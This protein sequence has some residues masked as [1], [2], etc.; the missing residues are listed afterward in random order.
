MTLK[1]EEKGK[2]GTTLYNQDKN[3]K[4]ISKKVSV[5]LKQFISL[6]ERKDEK[7]KIAEKLNDS[8]VDFLQKLKLLKSS[9]NC[10][11]DTDQLQNI[12]NL[13]ENMERL[14]YQLK[15]EKG[16]IT[17][18][19]MKIQKADA[20]RIVVWKRKSR[21]VIKDSSSFQ[22]DRSGTQKSIDVLKR[23][24]HAA[25]VQ[26][27]TE[28][29]KNFD[30]REK[31]RALMSERKCFNKNYNSSIEKLQKGKKILEDLHVSL[32]NA[33]LARQKII[34][35]IEKI[36]SKENKLKKIQAEE[37]F[38]LTMH[39][40]SEIQW[41]N[42]Y[43]I[44]IKSREKGKEEITKFRKMTLLRLQSTLGGN[45][46]LLRNILLVYGI[47]GSIDYT[48]IESD[49][50]KLIKKDNTELDQLFNYVTQLRDE[51]EAMQEKVFILINE[52]ED[53]LNEYD[54]DLFTKEKNVYDLEYRRDT[55]IESEFNISDDLMRCTR[56]M[57][58]IYKGIENLV[59]I[60]KADVSPLLDML[61]DKSTVTAF[62]FLL[63]LQALETRIIF[64]MD[65]VGLP[66]ISIQISDR[67]KPSRKVGNRK[68]SG[69]T[70]V[71]DRVTISLPCPVCYVSSQNRKSTLVLL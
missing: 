10:K 26:L 46:E 8:N 12:I 31:I 52:T 57:N 39:V 43:R 50:I 18:L 67:F 16:Y 34:N 42:Y 62:N 47:N 13:V 24:L 66:K 71:E 53:K 65:C 23:K 33:D 58:R 11:K 21:K 15:M 48:T 35:K 5:V 3:D 64:L 70:M 27:S 30:L 41:Q 22:P 29:S 36:Q 7:R 37:A 17:D 68:E 56:D 9:S 38:D 20:Q 44:K 19:E 55:L 49:L 2:A 63:F 6:K 32:K 61:G 60:S 51:L 25:S 69:I 40:D 28:S 14:E 54:D 1:M 4:L 45:L 59:E